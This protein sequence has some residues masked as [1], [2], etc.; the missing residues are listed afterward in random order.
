MFTIV[1][2]DSSLRSL[3]DLRQLNSQIKRNPFPQNLEGFYLATLLDL[4]CFPLLKINYLLQKL[5]GFHLATSLDLN[6]GY[7]PIK[8]TLEASALYNSTSMGKYKCRRL[9]I[10]LYNSPD[11][12]QKKTSELMMR[13]KFASAY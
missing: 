5:E 11:I 7:Y 13:L 4:K 12:F 6:I 1:K 10:E 9:P 2:P 8:L 3:A